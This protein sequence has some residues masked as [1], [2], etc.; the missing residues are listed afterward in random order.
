MRCRQCSLERAIL[1]TESLFEFHV[2]RSEGL[3]AAA[4]VSR[5]RF[6]ARHRI[7]AG[8]FTRALFREQQATGG[9]IKSCE[10]STRRDRG[11]ELLPVQP[12]GDHQMQ[13]QEEVSLELDDDAFSEPSHTDHS[14]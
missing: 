10:A 8:A 4:V 9:K 13:H 7:Q 11:T 1:R 2:A 5:E 6:A 14:A 12:P 3:E